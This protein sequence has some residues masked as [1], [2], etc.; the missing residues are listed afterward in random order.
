M[1]NKK[2][3]LNV[4]IT[5]EVVRRIEEEAEKLSMSRSLFVEFVFRKLF[6]LE[7]QLKGESPKMEGDPYGK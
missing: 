3:P 2:I 1:S 4:S 5:E 7:P 6:N